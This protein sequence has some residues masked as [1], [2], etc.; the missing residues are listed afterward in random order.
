MT[1]TDRDRVESSSYRDNCIIQYARKRLD[2]YV[3]QNRHSASLPRKVRC[4]AMF[5]VYKASMT[6]ANR[7]RLDCLFHLP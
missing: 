5:A 6:R 1:V 7:L 4:N 2:T 3:A